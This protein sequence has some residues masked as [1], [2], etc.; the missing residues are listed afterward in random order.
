MGL[1]G[2]LALDVVAY[3]IYIVEVVCKDVYIMRGVLGLGKG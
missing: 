2:A 3:K 1:L